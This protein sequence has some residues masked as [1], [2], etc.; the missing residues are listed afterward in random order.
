M[1]QTD[2][3]LLADFAATGSPA[4]FEELFRRHSPMVLATCRRLV[5][6]HDAED[7]TQAVFLLLSRKRRRLRGHANLAGWLHEAAV[8]TARTAARAAA[9]RARREKEATVHSEEE[10][11]RA[12]ER[13]RRAVRRDLDEAILSLPRRYR[14]VMTLCGLEGMSQAE[15]AKALG[16][17]EGT[18]ASL[19]SRALTKLRAYFGRRGTTVSGAV[20]GAA[21]AAE[22]AR[23]A[24]PMH[25][26]AS[27]TSAVGSGAAAGGVTAIM[28]GASK[29]MFWMKVKACLAV[30]ASTATAA[31]VVATAVV[32]AAQAE[33]RELHVSPKQLAGVA[34]EQFRSIS[35]AARA[36]ASGDTVV[37]HGGTYRESVKIERG[38]TATRPVRFVTATG[39]KVIVTGADVPEKIRREGG[40]ARRVYSFAWPH[41][42]IGWSK[43]F[44]HPGDEYHLLIG[45]SEQVFVRGYPLRQVLSRDKLTRGTFYVD[46]DAKRLYL[47]SADN[48]DLVKRRRTVEASSRTTLWECGADYVSVRGI[49]FRYAA[50]MA[51]HGAVKVSG[52]HNVFEDCVFEKMN[53]SGASFTGAN[54]VLRRCTFQDNGQLGFGASR[55]HDMLVTGCLVRN[56]NAKNYNRGWEAGGDKICHSRGVVIEKSTFV[57]NH[58]NGIWFDIANDKCTVRNCLIADNDDCGIFYEISFGLHAH[59]NV[60]VGNGFADTPG[61]WGAAAGISLSSSPF[62]IVERNLLIGNKEGFNF[63]E[64]DRKTPTIENKQENW[65]W[66]HDQIVR[67]NVMAYNRDAQTWGWFDIGD[68][69]HW[70]RAMQGKEYGGPAPDDIAA[71]YT[72]KD[73]SGKPVGLS[74]EKLN[75]RFERNLYHADPGQEL[76]NWGTAWKKNKRYAS[77][78][79][80]RAELKLESG[81]RVTRF[82]FEDFLTR[83][84]RVPSSSPAM[85][86]RC[87]PK[88]DVPAVVLGVSPPPR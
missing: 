6:H 7:A 41:R 9:R 38:G 67:N 49:R 40:G 86:M 85:R 42:F 13:E 46:L 84:F 78:D 52:R 2:R 22:A 69:R 23:A 21:L 59:D 35:A 74:L 30:I 81:S 4:A 48:A 57:D 20:I 39:A 26:L 56:N 5:G 77:L 58:G 19:R 63:R 27:L 50:N 15:A 72:A 16:K 65:V 25:L 47:Q 66:N 61:S 54:L 33:G 68:G 37:I 88:G 75:I 14:D 79:E 55:A 45:R 10:R 62:C 12:A 11:T 87:Y 70:P 44:T 34:G 36:A 64:Q 17:P 29:A 1:A 83:D 32:F 51:Q 76:F 28:E 82:E 8:F 80:V 24:A 73:G 3:E 60:I 18:V 31:A 71:K 53:S 43:Q